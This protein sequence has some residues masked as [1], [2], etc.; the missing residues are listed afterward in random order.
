LSIAANGYLA[1][2]Q[3]SKDRR[4]MYLLHISSNDKPPRVLGGL[5]NAC[6]Y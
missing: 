6:L 5:C 4:R 2:V 3:H 1:V